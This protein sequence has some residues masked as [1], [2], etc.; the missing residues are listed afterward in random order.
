MPLLVMACVNALM[1]LVLRLA[2]FPFSRS[3]NHCGRSE[4][5]IIKIIND[6]TS[7]DLSIELNPLEMDK[8]QHCLHRH[9]IVISAVVIDYLCFINTIATCAACVWFLAF[10]V[11]CGFHFANPCNEF[12]AKRV[13]VCVSA[14][15]GVCA[16]QAESCGKHEHWHLPAGSLS[17]ASVGGGRPGPPEPCGVNSAWACHA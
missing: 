4:I 12:A 13:R 6:E 7:N 11:C 1:L 10:S 9:Y 2:C 8:C 15:V 16:S 14:R 3:P 5:V 17:A